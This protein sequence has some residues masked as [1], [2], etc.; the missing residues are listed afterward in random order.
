M[1]RTW[2][3]KTRRRWGASSASSSANSNSCAGWRGSG[4]ISSCSGSSGSRRMPALSGSSDCT[5]GAATINACP[6]VA[7]RRARR[8]GAAGGV[9]RARG[10]G[11]RQDSRPQLRILVV[12][13]LLGADRRTAGDEHQLVV[14]REL[15]HLAGRQQRPRGLLARDHQMAEP[16]AQPM[17][18]IVLASRAFRSRCRARRR[19]AWRCARRWWRS[20]RGHGSCRGSSCSGRRPSRSGSGSAR[21]ERPSEP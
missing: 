3:C 19:R 4:A 18:G 14:G 17:T 13:R 1:V 15:H 10:L 20:S 16:R 21:S 12:A 8:G 7:V 2:P 6:I 5:G 11:R 9:R